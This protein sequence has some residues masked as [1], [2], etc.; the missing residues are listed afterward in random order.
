MSEN[1][2]YIGGKNATDRWMDQEIEE[3]ARL[4][5]T[6]VV[7]CSKE[8]IKGYMEGRINTSLYDEVHLLTMPALFSE[9]IKKADLSKGS[10]ARLLRQDSGDKYITNME[11]I[12]LRLICEMANE[13]CFFKS[14]NSMR[15]MSFS[16]FLPK[17][18]SADERLTD[19]MLVNTGEAQKYYELVV[20]Q[21][22]NIISAREKEI[23]NLTRKPNSIWIIP[24]DPTAGMDDLFL[25]CL[26][27]T[28]GTAPLS[29]FINNNVHL[30]QWRSLYA[31]SIQN[32]STYIRLPSL[33]FFKSMYPDRYDNYATM[34]DRIEFVG[35]QMMSSRVKGNPE[36]EIL[37]Y[38]AK[39]GDMNNLIHNIEDLQENHQLTLAK[40]SGHII[41]RPV[42]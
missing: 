26:Y 18:Q 1:V 5:E 39:N 37:S 30:S 14:V 16:E 4:G 8:D 20:T 6:I 12:L 42:A 25:E 41:S 22:H 32:V 10:I 28:G 35:E 29:I 7:L 9:Q 31:S 40:K 15:R 19:M 2:L 33:S 3:K 38:I 11:Y 21:L 13:N 23:K 24:V 27:H 34:M 36:E 17:A